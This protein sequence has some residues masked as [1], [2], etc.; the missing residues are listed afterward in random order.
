[1]TFAPLLVGWIYSVAPTHMHAALELDV[2]SIEAQ[3]HRFTA[4]NFLSPTPLTSIRAG[5]GPLLIGQAGDIAK[6]R[7]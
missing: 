1:M 4:H 3:I 2:Q 5:L 7:K 6:E